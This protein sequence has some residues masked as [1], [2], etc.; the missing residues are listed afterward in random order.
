VKDDTGA[1]SW[2]QEN[3]S[4]GH[5]IPV[6]SPIRGQ[7]WLLSHLVRNDPDLDRDAPWKSVMPL[8]ARL[9]DGWGRLRIDWWILNFTDSA[10]KKQLQSAAALFTLFTFVTLWSGWTLRRRL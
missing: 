2:F 8:P 5:Y 6:F 3:L 9:D 10:N 7:W 1:S 4:H